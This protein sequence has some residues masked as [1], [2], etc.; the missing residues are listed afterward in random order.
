MIIYCTQVVYYFFV[1][2]LVGD[3]GFVYNN[4]TELLTHITNFV[5]KGVDKSRDYNAYKEFSPEVVMQQFKK[6]FMDP[7]FGV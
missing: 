1:L 5:E 7:V 4:P 2:V 6:V 3:K